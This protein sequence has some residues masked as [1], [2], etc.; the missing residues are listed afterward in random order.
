MESQSRWRT[1]QNQGINLAP[2]LDV[3][4][5]LLFFFILATSIQRA[6]Q[7]VDVEIPKGGIEANPVK[8]SEPIKIII[9]ADNTIRFENKEMTGDQ[10]ATALQKAAQRIADTGET[11]PDRAFIRSHARADMQ[12]FVNVRDACAKAGLKSAVMEVNPDENQ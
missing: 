7:G 3:I 9:T 12:T 11:R 8:S 5:S 10:L 6:P 1:S 4:F 2:L